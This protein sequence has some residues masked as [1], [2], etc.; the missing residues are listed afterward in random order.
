MLQN[1]ISNA[2]VK[3]GLIGFALGYFYAQRYNVPDNEKMG[4]GIITGIA[5][6]ALGAP[7]AQTIAALPK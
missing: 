7:L 3:G 5:F 6:G 1:T 4:W 2:P